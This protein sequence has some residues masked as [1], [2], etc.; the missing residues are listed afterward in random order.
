MIDITS[1]NETSSAAFSSTMPSRTPVA[2]F[3]KAARRCLHHRLLNAWCRCVLGTPLTHI[4]YTVQ[5]ITAF[6]S[7][8]RSNPHNAATLLI[9]ISTSRGF[10]PG[11]LSNTCPQ[12]S[13]G[14]DS[15]AR[16]G[17][18]RTTLSQPP[19]VTVRKRAAQFT[20]LVDWRAPV[21]AGYKTTPRELA[22][23]VLVLT[24]GRWRHDA[25]YVVLAFCQAS[26]QFEAARNTDFVQNQA[27]ERYGLRFI[28]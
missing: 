4:D 10:L 20:V 1:I 11:G 15:S 16:T 27:I 26:S 28:C 23:T 13:P 24:G 8:R 12:A 2:S 22:R 14:L 3:C 5:T 21:R 18:C 7:C 6:L 9:G 25:I 19:G 17:R